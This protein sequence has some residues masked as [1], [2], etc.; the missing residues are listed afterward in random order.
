MIRPH[1][2]VSVTLD[3][4]STQVTSYAIAL[5]RAPLQRQ[6][7]VNALLQRHMTEHYWLVLVRKDCISISQRWTA[8]V[9]LLTLIPQLIRVPVQGLELLMTIQTSYAPALLGFT[10]RRVPVPVPVRVSEQWRQLVA[11]GVHPQL[12]C[13]VQSAH[14][15]RASTSTRQRVNACVLT[16]KPLYQD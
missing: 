14:V 11:A 2:L 15:P 13:Q 12:L 16:L 6:E 3:F 7:A 1:C 5:R 4:T 8:A 9:Q 10:M